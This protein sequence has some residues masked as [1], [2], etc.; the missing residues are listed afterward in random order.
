MEMEVQI[1]NNYRI[2]QQHNVCFCTR[3]LYL[4]LSARQL[5][6]HAVQEEQAKGRSVGGVNMVTGMAGGVRDDGTTIII[7]PLFLLFYLISF[8]LPLPFVLFFCCS[9]YCFSGRCII[10]IMCGRQLKIEAGKREVATTCASQ[11][12]LHT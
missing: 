10:F 8:S 3:Y 4:T 1:I 12:H 2:R 6:G 9:A 5:A 7:D 11:S